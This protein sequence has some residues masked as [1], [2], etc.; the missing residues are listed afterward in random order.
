M[1]LKLTDLKSDFHND[2][3]PGCGDFGI[4]SAVQ[5]AL[6]EMNIEPHRLALVS[7][8]GCSGKTPHFF[9]AYG[10][11]TLHGRSLPFA[12]GIKL[13]NPNLEVIACGG[14]GDGMGIG[15][16]HFVNSGRRNVDMTYIVY[17]N[18]VYGLTKG[19][20]APTL[21]LGVKTKSLP[22][23]NIN[24]AINPL[25]LALA[26]GYT[27]VARGYAY[28]VRHLKEV[29]KKAVRHRGFAFIDVL[30]PCP[31]YNDILTKEYWQGDGLLDAA[32][33]PMPR[34][35]KLDATGYDGVVK[36]ANVGEMEDKIKTA[37][38]KTFEFG[39][40]TPIG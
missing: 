33:R 32:G 25:M 30:Q 40:H 3:C 31:T 23:P 6:A 19:Q 12:T 18:G 8:I 21:Q 24:S 38:M 34:T 22:L 35:Y 9:K 1:A 20:A 16:G 27:F 29:I 17:D 11:H 4:I 15:A 14:D 5:M 39:A 7:G 26:S 13:S 10:V 37:M 36:T 2:W 28:D